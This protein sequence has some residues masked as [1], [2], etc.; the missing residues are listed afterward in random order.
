MSRVQL[1]LE[2]RLRK[3]LLLLRI[4]TVLYEE[5]W[6]TAQVWG[7]NTP[8]NG[9]VQ[10]QYCSLEIDISQLMVT[11]E[12]ILGFL[13]NWKILVLTPVGCVFV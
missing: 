13:T 4:N 3:P 9:T 11:G 2:A 8:C 10:F 7:A 5:Q 12:L 1:T 6:L